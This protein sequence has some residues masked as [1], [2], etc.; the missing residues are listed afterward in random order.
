MILRASLGAES[1]P[2]P[3]KGSTCCSAQQGVDDG[4]YRRMWM[5]EKTAVDDDA[6]EDV[7]GDS[8]GEAIDGIGVKFITDMCFT[9]WT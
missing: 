6:K 1:I 7:T 5:E 3:T 9:N 8:C 4:H 2:S